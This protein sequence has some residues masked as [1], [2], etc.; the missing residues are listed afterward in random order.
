MKV[1]VG[2]AGGTGGDPS[3][4]KRDWLESRMAAGRQE[5]EA[6]EPF[7]TFRIEAGKFAGRTVA[8]CLLVCPQAG[9]RHLCP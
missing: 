7:Q 9:R 4:C 6:S 2:E 3:S 8:A 1:R 5:L